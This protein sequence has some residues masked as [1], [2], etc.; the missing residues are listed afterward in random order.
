MCG[1]AGVIRKQHFDGSTTIGVMTDAMRHR[2]PDGSGFVALTPGRPRNKSAE[3]V[4]RSGMAPVWLG[5]RRLS[6]IDLAGS[7]QPLRNE[8]GRIWVTFNGEIYNYESLRAVLT[9]K[10]HVLREAG[11]SE[12][13]VHL[14]EEYGES[15]VEHLIGM[16]AFA[17]YDL[18]QNVLYFARDRFG[19]KPLYY[20][21]TQVGLS[22]AS[23]LQA[24]KND[25]GF[26]LGEIDPIAAAQYF[27]YGYI[28]SPKTIYRGVNSLPAGHYA[29]YRDGELQTREYWRPTVRSDGEPIDYE[30][31]GAL[32]DESVAARLKADVPIGAFLSGGI[33]SSLIV[34]S[35]AR[36]MNRP[37]ETFTIS[38]GHH[39]CDESE[40]AQA[41]ANHLH[42]NHHTFEVKPDLV[43]V[44]ELLT[45]NY[46][47]PF[48][49]YSNV[50]TYYVCRETRQH[51]TVALSGDG[52]DELF[53]GYRRYA[54]FRWS[55]IAGQMPYPLRLPIAASIRTL[56]AIRPELCGRISD[57]LLSA[58]SVADKGENHS[59]TFHRY[60]RDKTFQP[61]FYR[62]MGIAGEERIDRFADL[63]R[64][65]DS[66]EPIDRWLE[67][68]QRMYL[69][70]DILVKVD[71]ASMAV[72][73]ECR[74]PMLDHRFAEAANRISIRDKLKGGRTKVPLRKLAERRVPAQIIDLPK[75]GFT[76]PMAAWLRGE[77]A[78]WAESL[79][80]DYESTWESFL[81]RDAVRRLWSEHRDGQADHHMRIWIILAWILW[82]REDGK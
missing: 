56:G 31:L 45:R 24:L 8:D 51:V 71:I 21:H 49:D 33:D 9:S 55:A 26:P 59:A 11:D 27:R 69:A 35:M 57:F 37:V 52:G 60:W 81:C 65:A 78:S 40:A 62:L 16:F 12:V 74:A 17:I 19:K 43:E 50:P 76:L 36:Q 23:E 41:T 25:E 79:L 28:P 2:G 68:D 72:S 48:A 67:A 10:G 22:F 63:C 38:T 15:M 18:G 70:D 47:Q 3:Y 58:G 53:A 29:L 1:I 61:E 80:F 82:R 64:A 4:P 42:T 66:P 13:L 30:H 73:L 7:Q 6:I 39:W 75:R 5:H 54:N 46:G 44:I 14:W 34:A 77:L 20:R 32:L